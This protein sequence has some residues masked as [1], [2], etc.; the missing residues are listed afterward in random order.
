MGSVCLLSNAVCAGLKQMILK[1][2]LCLQSDRT[3]ISTLP[4]VSP[5]EF[6]IAYQWSFLIVALRATLKAKHT[7]RTRVYIVASLSF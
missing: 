6:N 3:S 5:T 7:Q 2:I 4:G 1:E